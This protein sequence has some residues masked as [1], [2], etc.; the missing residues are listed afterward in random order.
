[1]VLLKS[2]NTPLG[3]IVCICMFVCARV[4]LC[5]YMYVCIV[6]VFVCVCIVCVCM[7]V[8]CVCVCVYC[9]CVCV[10]CVCVCVLCVCVCVCMCAYVVYT[11]TVYSI[12]TLHIYTT[13]QVCMHFFGMKHFSGGSSDRRL[14]SKSC[15]MCKYERP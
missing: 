11:H 15:G 1:M 10:L 14:T 13:Y 9:V 3:V 4:C 5:T 12:N 7:C 2:D 6:C 8:H